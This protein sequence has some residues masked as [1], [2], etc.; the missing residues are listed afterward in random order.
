MKLARIILASVAL[1]SAAACSSDRITAPE[2]PARPATA[3]HGTLIVP[4]D[5]TGGVNLT[6]T[7]TTKTELVNGVLTAVVS[8]DSGWLG[9][10]Q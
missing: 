1:L 4:G 10:G 7:C 2:A 6:T 5:S 9:G 3:P 8:C